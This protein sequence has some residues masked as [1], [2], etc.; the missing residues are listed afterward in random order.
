MEILKKGIYICLYLYF[1]NLEIISL[2]V[3][4]STYSI[5]VFHTNKAAVLR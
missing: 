5:A 1:R 3:F 2:L 4:C